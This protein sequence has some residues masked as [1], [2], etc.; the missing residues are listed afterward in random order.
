MNF[1]KFSTFKGVEGSC[2][3]LSRAHAEGIGGEADLLLPT[4]QP[5]S[6]SISQAETDVQ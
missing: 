4:S 5:F 1:Q 2:R 6:D 3:I